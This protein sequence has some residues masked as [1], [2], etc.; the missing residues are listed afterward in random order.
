M[1]S[2]RN[3]MKK[4]PFKPKSF[5]NGR[6]QRKSNFR[7]QRLLKMPPE[8]KFF[9]TAVSF[10]PDI[11]LEVPATGQWALI[12]QGD[13]QSTRDGRLA[14][15]TSIQFRGTLQGPGTAAPA[16]PLFYMWVIQ[17]TQANGAAATAADVFDG[18]NVHRS[19]LIQKGLTQAAV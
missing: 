17:D 14:R 13:T 19:I 10:T 12:P 9:D 18:A 4:R 16:S 8:V 7:V 5:A 15:I 1:G 11:T 6:V 3:G 2:V